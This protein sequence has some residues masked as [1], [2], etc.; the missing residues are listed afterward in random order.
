MVSSD[1]HTAKNDV[2]IKIL[3][4]DQRLI[5]IKIEDFRNRT[6]VTFGLTDQRVILEECPAQGQRPTVADQPDIGECLLDDYSPLRAPHKKD[7]IE[8]A[9]TYFLNPPMINIVAKT[10][11]QSAESAK[12]RGQ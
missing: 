9:I 6:G 12:P 11:G 10:T 2:L 7:E 1:Q 5:F 3:H 8:I 4:C